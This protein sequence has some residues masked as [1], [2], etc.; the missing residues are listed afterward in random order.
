MQI[1]VMKALILAVAASTVAGAAIA[2]S[3]YCWK[4]I[5]AE[6]SLNQVDPSAFLA[7]G[8]S[9]AV[10]NAMDQAALFYFTGVAFCAVM[11]KGLPFSFVG[12]TC[13]GLPLNELL[14]KW[15]RIALR[16]YVFAGFCAGACLTAICSW[17][18]D[19]ARPNI[20]FSPFCLIAACAFC[21]SMV[22]ALAFWVVIRPDKQIEAM[23]S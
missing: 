1:K 18:V 14:Q 4:M 8:Q 5:N 13:L 19:A 7:P 15:H 6:Q 23:A 16:D 12:C 11:L 3:F 21:C 17:I 22:A 2:A 10:S 20:G 9:V